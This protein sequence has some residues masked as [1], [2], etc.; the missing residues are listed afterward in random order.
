MFRLIRALA[1]ATRYANARTS[2]GI[3]SFA[4][5]FE[6]MG[7]TMSGGTGGINPRIQCNAIEGQTP[8]PF[9][10]VLIGFGQS[11]ERGLK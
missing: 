1:N 6:I 2:G 9:Q 3:D 5:R 8:A 7:L 11:T 10:P 4:A